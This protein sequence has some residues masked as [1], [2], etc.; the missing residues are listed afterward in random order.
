MLTPQTMPEECRATLGRDLNKFEEMTFA[1]GRD[2]ARQWR[3]A[4]DVNRSGSKRE[5]AIQHERSPADLP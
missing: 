5:R 3:K 1:V 2:C 4:A